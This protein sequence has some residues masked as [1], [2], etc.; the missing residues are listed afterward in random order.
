MMMLK[1]PLGRLF[2]T[3]LHNN[4]RLFSVHHEEAPTKL[5]KVADIVYS[6]L[7]AAS[8]ST[9]RTNTEWWRLSPPSWVNPSS[10]PSLE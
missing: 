8:T 2:Q 4:R 5:S 1:G 6:A 10:K 9:S 7:H 3:A